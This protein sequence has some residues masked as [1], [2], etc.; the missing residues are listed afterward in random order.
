M[1][2]YRLNALRETTEYQAAS[3]E[4]KERMS[5]EVE[6]DVEALYRERRS[7]AYNKFLE[8]VESAAVS[9]SCNQNNIPTIVADT[10]SSG[11]VW[12]SRGVQ[13]TPPEQALTSHGV[14]EVQQ[15]G[16]DED[17]NSIENL[18]D[19]DASDDVDDPASIGDSSE[20][21]EEENIVREGLSQILV[22][23]GESL[24]DRLT[25]EAENRERER[26]G[27]VNLYLYRF[28][29]SL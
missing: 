10:V 12:I 20:E 15:P 7:K 25:R 11:K 13:T 17:G 27:R 19:F 18:Y 4:G 14:C 6:A 24:L 1:R 2:R 28:N 3:L 21:D 16:F 29:R 5:S 9:S 23:E 8:P 22:N 26:I